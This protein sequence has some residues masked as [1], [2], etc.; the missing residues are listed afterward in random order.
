[1]DL[2]MLIMFIVGTFL[3]ALTYLA[4]MFQKEY[5]LKMSF[6][7]KVVYVLSF[8][9]GGRFHRSGAGCLAQ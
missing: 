9:A 2:K 3:G 7:Q 5:L 4:D 8:S 6:F 1:M